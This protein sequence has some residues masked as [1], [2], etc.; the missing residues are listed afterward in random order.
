M[1]WEGS[2]KIPKQ[3]STQISTSTTHHDS[4]N[5]L[6]KPENLYTVWGISPEQQT[7]GHHR[8][9]V[10]MINHLQCIYCYIWFD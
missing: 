6:L 1:Y 3:F 5:P 7:V 8:V 10:G 9:K 2:N 4:N